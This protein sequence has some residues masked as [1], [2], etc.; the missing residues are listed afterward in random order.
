MTSDNIHILYG[1]E[2]GNGESIA[3]FLMEDINNFHVNGKV[4]LSTLNDSIDINYIDV[5]CIIIICST[6]G[7]GEF[8][9]NASSWWRYYKNR[10]IEKNVFANINFI[11]FGLGD[12]NYSYFCNSIKKI[13]KRIMELAGTKVMNTTYIDD[14]VDSEDVISEWISNVIAKLQQL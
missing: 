14:A 8:P 4:T 5:K 10:I 3:K 1:S 9:E 13:D 2:T 6:T 11:L 12:T 7:N